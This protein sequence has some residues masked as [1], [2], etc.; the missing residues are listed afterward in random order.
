[1]LGASALFLGLSTVAARAQATGGMPGERRRWV[2]IEKEKP[3]RRTREVTLKS[4]F[5]ALLDV[6]DGSQDSIVHSHKALVDEVVLC[7]GVGGEEA[8]QVWVMKTVCDSRVSC[9]THST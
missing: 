5:C 1:M 7:C 6:G 9:E 4:H 3:K 2:R 8:A